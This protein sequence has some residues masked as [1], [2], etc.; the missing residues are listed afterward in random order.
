M[1]PVYISLQQIK[2]LNPCAD[3]FHAARRFFGKRKRVAVS[4][5]VAVVLAQRFDFN[6]LAQRTLTRQSRQAYNAATAPA[7]QAYEAATAR[8][9]ALQVYD[10]AMAQ[11]WARCYINQSN[12]KGNP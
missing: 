4:V 1:K 9:Q 7:Q 8:A 6:W 11:A 2:A 12:R 3:Q 10:A 5:K